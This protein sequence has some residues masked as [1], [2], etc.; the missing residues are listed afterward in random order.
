MEMSYKKA[1]AKG[2]EK[3]VE[4]KTMNRLKTQ[5]KA[6]LPLIKY[7]QTGLLLFTGFTGYISARCPVL[8]L[9]AFVGFIG[10]LFLAISGSTVLNMVFDRDI[11]ATMNRTSDR[12]LPAGKISVNQAL[13]L[14]LALSSCGLVWSFLLSFLYGAIVFAGLFTDVVVYTI[15]LKRKTAWS[16]V[17]GGIS[18]GMPIL[19]GRVL[20]LGHLDIIGG[21]LSLAV[22][23]WIPTHIVSFSMKYHDDYRRAGIPTFPST[24]GYRNSRLIIAF[25]SLGAAFAIALGIF[26]LG[27]SWG[28]LRLLAVLTVGMLGLALLG[29][30]RPSEKINSGLFKYASF[31]ML[32]SMLMVVLGV[33]G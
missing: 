3:M 23:L 12:P 26:A 29:I 15:W 2:T 10:S 25:S 24:Y 22:L 17:W 4:E 14:G 8:P 5:F 1:L 11:D 33:L 6:Y 30:F 9:G 20:G 21:F 16:I 28:Y 19:A 18:G 27:L 7:R 13:F 32:I 31:Y